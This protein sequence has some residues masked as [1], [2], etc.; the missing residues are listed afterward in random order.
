MPIF[1]VSDEFII[2]SCGLDSLVSTC[3]FPCISVLVQCIRSRK[4]SKV[5]TVH[6]VGDALP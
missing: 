1:T 3:M 6:T 2:R 5:R 4:Y